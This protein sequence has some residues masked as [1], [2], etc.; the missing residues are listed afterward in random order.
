VLQRRINILRL[1]INLL[2]R[3]LDL[4]LTFYVGGLSKSPTLQASCIQPYSLQSDYKAVSVVPV[5]SHVFLLSF[6]YTPSL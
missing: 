1:R 5:K 4:F 2:R 6:R 3:Q